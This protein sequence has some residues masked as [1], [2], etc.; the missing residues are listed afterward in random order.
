M[1]CRVPNSPS[2]NRLTP[3]ASTPGRGSVWRHTPSLPPKDSQT[4]SVGRTLAG[5]TAWTAK[6]SRHRRDHHTMLGT[7]HPTD[8]GLQKHLRLT[9]IK[10]PPTARGPSNGAGPRWCHS[11]GSDVDNA[12]NAGPPR[13]SGAPARRAPPHRARRVPTPPTQSPCARP[14]APF[15]TPSSCARRSGLDRL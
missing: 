4:S 9:E 12:N 6:T 10:A 3:A 14:R 2:A 13:P 8:R 1:G 11:P 5:R 7:R 15:A